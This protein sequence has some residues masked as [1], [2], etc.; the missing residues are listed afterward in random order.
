M[1]REFRFKP[2][3]GP[4]EPWYCGLAEVDTERVLEKWWECPHCQGEYKTRAACEKH[5]I[6]V[7][8]QFPATCKETKK[9]GKCYGG[10]VHG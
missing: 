10:C 2:V 3:K 7:V 5:A 6:G 4:F 1:L 8:G 9:G